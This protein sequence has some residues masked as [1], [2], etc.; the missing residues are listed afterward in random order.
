MERYLPPLLI[1]GIL[2]LLAALLLVIPDGEWLPVLLYLALMTIGVRLLYMTTIRPFTPHLP[3]ALYWLAFLAKMLGGVA[4]Y[5]VLFGLYS[6]GDAGVYHRGA[7]LLA[8]SIS[9]YGLPAL[10]Q[11][12]IPGSGAIFIMTGLLYS[13]LPSSLPAAYLFYATLG[14]VG[15]IFFYRAFRVAFPDAEPGFYTLMIFFLPSIL[16]WPSS[17]G[18]E[19]LV[20]FGS[21]IAAYGFAK[22][23]R[24]AR[25]W[26]LVIA[27]LGIGVVFLPRPHF[28]AFMVVAAGV[29]FVLFRRIDTA[30]GLLT[31]LVAGG[32]IIGLGVPLIRTSGE[33]IG[34]EWEQGVWEET[35]ATFEFRQEQATSGGS[36]FVPVDPFTV[37]GLLAAPV[38][39]LLRPFVWEVD[40][41]QAMLSAL[42]STV[43]L[44]LIFARRR[45]L[46]DRLRT[47]RTN[48]MT[49][50]ALTYSV[51]LIVGLTVAGNFGIIARQRVALLPFVWMLFG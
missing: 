51:I 19:S 35:E 1:M 34:L 44:V 27:G 48:P 30:R 39:V 42:E 45:V 20:F 13:V 14:F 41:T 33:Y 29:S 18:K 47:M 50:F 28:A 15:S 26:D 8:R 9:Q 21:G 46:W 23:A 49:F 7:T 40:N 25:L 3:A 24:R 38:T 31:T 2:S 10:G 17:V 16:F 11:Y 6:G 5:W 32:L 12:S 37:G 36:A 22:Y 43:W 4:R